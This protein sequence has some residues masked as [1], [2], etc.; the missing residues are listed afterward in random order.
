LYGNQAEINSWQAVQVDAIYDRV[1][2]GTQTAHQEVRLDLLHPPAPSEHFVG[3]ED[4]IK[5]ISHVLQP[6]ARRVATLVGPGG[7]G[8]TQSA[9]KLVE[10]QNEQ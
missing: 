5:R 8:K 2:D 1:V 7:S 4:L 6:D 3:R 10:V 9:L